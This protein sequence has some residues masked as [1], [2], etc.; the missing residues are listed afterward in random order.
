MGVISPAEW[1]A[2]TVAARER[3]KTIAG[4]SGRDCKAGTRVPIASP[5]R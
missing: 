5:E 4:G 2:Q 1:S 3:R